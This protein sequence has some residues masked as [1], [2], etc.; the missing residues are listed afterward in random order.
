MNRQ[1]VGFLVRGKLTPGEN[2]LGIEPLIVASPQPLPPLTNALNQVSSSLLVNY[3][4]SR[5]GHFSDKLAV[6]RWLN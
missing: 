3:K 1:L 6:G 5:P 4:I 2:V